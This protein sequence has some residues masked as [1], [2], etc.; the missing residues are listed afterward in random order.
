M[1]K[2]WILLLFFAPA[3]VAQNKV[4][5]DV[6]VKQVNKGK[7]VT[8]RK[9]IYLNTNGNMVVKFNHPKEYYMITNAFGEARVY[10]PKTNEV[11]LMND[12]FLSS[13]SESIYYFMTNQIDDLGLKKL[14]LSLT[15]TRTE[16]KMIIR[17]YTPGNSN[18]K[19]SKVELVHENQLPIYSAYYDTKNQVIEKSY[20]SDYQKLSF[21]IF[22]K[23]ITSISYPAANDSI[24]SRTLFTNVKSGKDATSSYFN[25]TVPAN[26]KKVDGNT[27]FQQQGKR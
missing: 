27:F 10:H 8:V 4:S 26:A 25:F 1:R 3:L 19:L 5:F 11:M 17:T 22:P 21:A 16:G 23:R 9:E 6:E 15:S 18:S 24:I 20:Y 13:E 14:G 7:S 12:K 2:I